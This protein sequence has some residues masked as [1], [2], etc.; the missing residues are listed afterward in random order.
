VQTLGCLVKSM[1]DGATLEAAG[2]ETLLAQSN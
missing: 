1:E 2:I